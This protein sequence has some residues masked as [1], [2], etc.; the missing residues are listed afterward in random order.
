MPTS[1]HTD[2]PVEYKEIPGFP[3]YL[4][5]PDRKIW[6]TKRNKYVKVFLNKR[7]IECVGLMLPKGSLNPQRTSYV[8]RLYKIT[9]QDF[10][11]DPDVRYLGLVEYPGY[12]VGDDGSV[13]SYWT[14]YGM[15]DVPYKIQG[16]SVNGHINIYL[17]NIKREIGAH[18]LVLTAFVGP[19]PPGMQGC[20]YDDDG[21]NNRLEN[22]RWDTPLGNSQD[23]IRNDRLHNGEDNGAAKISN[24]DVRR[25]KSARI[26]NTDELVVLADELG[27]HRIT[28]QRIR[29]GKSRKKC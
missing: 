22:L 29:N 4:M 24:R 11:F 16:H 27:V 5:T 19:R 28:I 26:R 23:A 25:I 14:N 2:A 7:G 21:T 10:G 15:T 8:D 1:Q 13:W 3:G 17:Q 20:H 12:L 9:Y 18:V 6:S